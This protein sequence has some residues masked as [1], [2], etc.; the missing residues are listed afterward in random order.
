[1]IIWRRASP[2]SP[3][4]YFHEGTFVANPVDMVFAAGVT[5]MF[6]GVGGILAAACKGLLIRVGRGRSQ[7]V[8]RS[9]GPILASLPMAL[10]LAP[11]NLP[12][13]RQVTPVRF[14]LSV[15]VGVPIVRG[16]VAWLVCADEREGVRQRKH[17]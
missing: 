15:L 16:L 1:M 14:A 7:S 3:L 9:L 2:P 4:L 8:R 12:V 11:A 6:A 13:S 5:A 17:G 10:L